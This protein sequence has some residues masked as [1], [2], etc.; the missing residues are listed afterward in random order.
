MLVEDKQMDLR[1][2]ELLCSRLCHDLISSISAI[3]NGMELLKELGP[4]ALADTQD[5]IE[6]SGL[7][8]TYK[9]R[10]FRIAYGSSGNEARLVDIRDAAVHYFSDSKIQL[11]W[12]PGDS[13]PDK[14]GIGKVLLNVILLAAETLGG[15]GTIRVELNAGQISVVTTGRTMPLRPDIEQ[16]LGQQID[17]KSLDP[18]AA[19]ALVTRY[20]AE[21]IGVMLS[22]HPSP[23]KYEF[24]LQW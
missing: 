23:E 9:L 15:T 12:N 2:A 13:Q 22:Y 20:F 24:Q 1:I 5:L 18:K 19:H 8:A 17:W 4:E 6:Q 10:C 11:E 16:A 7:Q 21:R 14:Y 3:N